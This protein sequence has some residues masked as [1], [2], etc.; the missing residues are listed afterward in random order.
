VGT[1]GGH[2][3]HVATSRNSQKLMG[4]MRDLQKSNDSPL[5]HPK[6]S[7]PTLPTAMRDILPFPISKVIMA[8]TDQRCHGKTL[9]LMKIWATIDTRLRHT[10]VG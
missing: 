2:D 8:E 9:N 6:E 3:I 10:V 7:A 4:I 1:Q 5:K